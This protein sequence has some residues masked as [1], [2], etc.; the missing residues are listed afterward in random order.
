MKEI[1]PSEEAADLQVVT[2]FNKASNQKIVESMV[3]LDGLLGGFVTK[4]RDSGQFQANA[5]ETLVITPPPG[6]VAA[7]QLLIIGLGDSSK[8]FLD[9][10]DK[11]GAVVAREAVRLRAATVAFAPTLRDQSFST[12]DTGQVAARVMNGAILGYDTEARLQRQAL[13]TCFALKHWYYE[14]G[15]AYFSD[16]VG[17]VG[18]AVKAAA[19]QVNSRSDE[20]FGKTGPQAGKCHT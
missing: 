19:E 17:K 18:P 20:P 6:T 9:L 13:K 2:L 4:V 3:E 11:V 15:A 1:G 14:A 16:V 7:R 12:L 10:M 8:T 5:L